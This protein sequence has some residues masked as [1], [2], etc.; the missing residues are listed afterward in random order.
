MDIEYNYFRK[1]GMWCNFLVSWVLY[2]NTILLSFYLNFYPHLKVLTKI[3]F[4]VNNLF[5]TVY[6]L[7][8]TT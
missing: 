1:I 5:I 3:P 6:K 4:F 8:T 7:V 2:K